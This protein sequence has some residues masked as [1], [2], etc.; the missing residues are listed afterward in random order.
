[1]QNNRVM[2]KNKCSIIKSNN[3]PHSYNSRE[4]NNFP[5]KGSVS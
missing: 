2:N 5:G 4:P 1:M 3:T